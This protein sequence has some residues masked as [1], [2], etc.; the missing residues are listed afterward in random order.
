MAA[1][2]CCVSLPALAQ[3]N[4]PVV[5][6]PAA[7]TAAPQAPALTPEQQAAAHRKA[8]Y[9]LGQQ[10]AQTIGGELQE[11]D[12]Y[13]NGAG[14]MELAEHKARTEL[15]DD[16][17]LIMH[18]TADNNKV[19]F[20][21][22][23]YTIK[24]GHKLFVSLGD[25]CTSTDIA[26]SVHPAK[27]TADGW[28]VHEDQTFH[29]DAKK[30]EVTISG[31]T[32]PVDPKDIDDSD[33]NNLLVSTV[34]LEKW[35]GISFDYDFAAL[36][37]L[38]TT[39]Q[40]LPAEEAYN[41]KMKT[42]NKSWGD[43]QA[44]LP[45]M[46]VPY[47]MATE[48]YVDVTTTTSVSKS[49]ETP[50][51]SINGWSAITNSD[52]AGF[53]L[54]TFSSGNLPTLTADSSPQQPYLTN[55]RAT[56]GKTD[57][58]GNLLGAL[59]A[60][61]YAVGDVTTVSPPLIGNGGVEQGAAVS[62][63]PTDIVT[64]TSTEI[65]GNA[66]PGWDVELYRNNV[67]MTIQHV[68]VTGLYDFKDV[69]LV[70]G[71]N[72]MKMLFYGPHG[73]IN[74]QHKHILVDPTLLAQRTGYYNVSVSRNNINTFN[75]I[76]ANAP[77]GPGTG[78]PN[79]AATYQYGL[80]RLGTLDFGV[81]RHSDNGIERT[82]SEAGLATFIGSGTYVN[83]NVGADD[84]SG[85]STQS[86]TARRNFGDQAGVLTYTHDSPKFSVVT[87][88]SAAPE[89]ESGVASLSGP[90]PGKFLTLDHLNYSMDAT[91]T[92]NYDSSSQLTVS[93]T[94]SGRLQNLSV[95]GSVGYNRNVSSTGQVT[96]IETANFIGHG[97]MF[98]G[99]W[100]VT[101]DY[102]VKPIFQ[103]TETDVEYD[104]ALGDSVD[105]TSTVKYANDPR[106]I[107][108]SFALNWRA[109]KATI[110]PT[111]SMDSTN[112]MTAAVNVHFGT[113]ADPYSHKYDMYNTFMSG[114]GGVAAR[115][116]F[117]KNGTGIYQQ[118]DELMPD[119]A[120]KALQVHRTAMT[121]TR[122][123][124][125]IPD[126]STNTVTDVV[127][128]SATFKDSYDISLFEGV[129]IRTHAGSVT[130]LDFPVV[131]GGEL[132]GQADYIDESGVHKP[133]G[134]LKI[135][136]IAPDGTVEKTAAAAF[137]GYYA[138]SSI[139]PGVYYLT[140]KPDDDDTMDGSFVP[141]MVVFKPEGTTLFGQG[142]GL[143]P[144]Y[145]TRFIYV[146]ENAAPSG[147]R[148]T[149]VIKPEDIDSQK[150]QIRLGEYHS[151]LA[152]TFSWYRFRIR[153]QWGGDYALVKPLLD[154]TPDPKT[155]LMSLDLQPDAPL[156][157]ESAAAVCQAMQADKFP[158]AV[159]VITKYRDPTLAAGVP[160]KAG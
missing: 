152:L 83:T 158:C 14:K 39:T 132:D 42:G 127:A 4:T 148:H 136:L 74:E 154:I 114:V 12:L 112:N 52:V 53:N 33:P 41:R 84:Q 65:T 145:S 73:E 129:S 57:P 121:D 94:V 48:P 43:E 25:F 77:A 28:F 123:V 130:Q 111:V 68:D 6:A 107:T 32:M 91:D 137:D 59:H 92:F 141:R 51:T 88:G 85:A 99:N 133:A 116:F 95:S 22:D 19:F 106:L 35:F 55:L 103:A 135:S 124:A 160:G 64:Q 34:L 7:Q 126:I 10:F 2:L 139:R 54:E 21:A 26:I 71:D 143:K 149:R 118:G 17:P 122:G 49:P 159:K 96:D 153:S 125:F 72:D 97:F 110:S 81:R 70:L 75:P 31:K 40:A 36:N 15:P 9:A 131:T 66:Q 147:A 120:V 16:E 37:L 1:L 11:A 89:K 20:N 50:A 30:H 5:Q 60:T 82:F 62:N 157:M 76:P 134:N 69:Q 128:D 93:P 108:G 146:S 119:V 144:G 115:V 3:D 98:G 102:N 8:L 23:I 151:R 140:V 78:D 109:A 29:L 44:K 13:L 117:D 142:I 150:V 63:A 56:L 24:R 138:V 100:R 58:D 105:T 79:V 46:D 87:Q 156:T 18:A 67:Y 104:H 155:Q 47:Q 45:R 101:T 27:G 90:L 61:S 38:L 86:I 113:A 80:G